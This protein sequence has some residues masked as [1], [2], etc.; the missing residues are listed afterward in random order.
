[1]PNDRLASEATTAFPDVASFVREVAF[2]D[3]PPDVALRATRC[4]LDLIGI[5]ADAGVGN[6]AFLCRVAT[7]RAR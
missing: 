3:L 4:L 6:R 5:D 7:L 2:A 1:M